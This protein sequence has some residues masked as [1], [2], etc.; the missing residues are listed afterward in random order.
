MAYRSTVEFIAALEKAGELVRVP[1]PVATELEITAWA[2]REMKSPGGGKALLFE[3][4]T[5]NGVV[6]SFP[7]AV[8]TMGSRARMALAL[9]IADVDELMQQMRLILK[10]KPPT[11]LRSAWTLALQGLDLLNAKPNRVR[12]GP[13]QEVVYRFEKPLTPQAVSDRLPT[14]LDLP[15]LQSG[16]TTAVASSPFLASTPKIPIPASAT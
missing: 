6:S 10:A 11:N 3:K 1:F 7:L 4:P 14:L 9:G 16:P 2:D 15:I 5:V 12:T 8:N 13:A